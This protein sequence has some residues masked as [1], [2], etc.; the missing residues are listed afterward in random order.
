MR[1]L[2]NA[3]SDVLFYASQ[4]F[5][6][7]TLG[8]WSEDVAPAPMPEEVEIIRDALRTLQEFKHIHQC[9]AQSP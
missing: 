5:N 7:D 1:V 4:L 3:M 8:R 2:R 9:P 6:S